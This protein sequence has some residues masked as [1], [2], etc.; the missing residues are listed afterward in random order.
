VKIRQSHIK[1]FHRCPYAFKLA[2]IEGIEGEKTAIMEEGIEKH[3]EVEKSLLEGVIP[4]NLMPIF[5]HLSL[6][7][8][9]AEVEKPLEI[10]V[11]DKVSITAKLDFVKYVGDKAIILDWKFSSSEHS[12]NY[13]VNEKIQPVIY[14]HLAIE[15]DAFAERAEFY[16]VF[17]AYQKIIPLEFDRETAKEEFKKYVNPV[18]KAINK[19]EFTPCFSACGSCLYKK[20]CEYMR[21]E[22][23]DI[24]KYEQKFEI[25]QDNAARVYQFIEKASA[26]VNKLK[27]ELKGKMI[28]GEISPIELAD[29]RI[30]QVKE[31]MGR[32]QVDSKIIPFLI[33]NGISPLEILKIVKLSYNDVKKLINEVPDRYVKQGKSFYV[34]EAKK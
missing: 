28:N 5:K 29:G 9:E 23:V 33:D 25:T 11:T 7:L 34:I 19:N 26:I 16:F 31:R 30:L 20:H 13:Y 21:P 24:T 32:K 6:T 18:I 4:E 17:P 15:T 1:L 3:K 8:E 27:E 14:S 10:K 22:S 12:L 2:A